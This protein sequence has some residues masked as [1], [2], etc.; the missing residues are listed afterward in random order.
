VILGFIGKAI[1]QACS[2]SLFHICVVHGHELL[3]LLFIILF[4]SCFFD[5]VYA[6]VCLVVIGTF[7]V[8]KLFLF[9]RGVIVKFALYCRDQGFFELNVLPSYYLLLYAFHSTIAC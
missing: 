3:L 2:P 5:C 4:N 9:A 1:A 7:L 6:Y 8:M